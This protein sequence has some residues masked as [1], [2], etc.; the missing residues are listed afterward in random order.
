MPSSSS[1]TSPVAPATSPPVP[2]LAS[3]AE[4]AHPHALGAF[5]VVVGLLFVCHGSAA[6][7]GFPEGMGRT[8]ALGTWP[9][10]YAAV[11]QFAGGLLVLLGLGTRA[12]AFISSGS[13][14]YAYFHVHQPRALLPLDNGGEPAALFCWA[15]LLLVF[16]GPGSA[17]L[18]PALRRLRRT[19]EGQLA[20]SVRE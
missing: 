7:F 17:A 5:R 19:R 3:R 11:I 9:G 20:P 10:W 8:V 18:G 16:A 4:R 6:L 1:T 15:M 13:M 14:A 2:G 12:A